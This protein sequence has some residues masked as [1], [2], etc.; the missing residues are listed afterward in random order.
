MT[1]IF[2]FSVKGVSSWVVGSI[3]N[4]ISLLLFTT[5]GNSDN[6]LFC[7]L[8]NTIAIYGFLFFWK[9]VREFVRK[10]K[11]SQYYW[12]L[13][14][15]VL[16]AMHYSFKVR[17]GFE[18]RSILMALILGSL[19]LLSGIDLY[20]KCPSLSEKIAGG[21]FFS[22][23]IF[24]AIKL[25]LV[26]N[27]MKINTNLSSEFIAIYTYTF[28]F[29]TIFLYTFGF[30]LMIGEKLQINLHEQSVSDPLTSI[31]NM[32]GF[33]IFSKQ[34]F[35]NSKLYGHK[36][37]LLILDIDNFKHINDSFGYS[38]GDAVICRFTEVISKNIRERDMFFRI[39]GEEFVI[40]LIDIDLKTAEIIAERLR[41]VIETT[42][43]LNGYR[44]VNFTISIGMA[45]LNNS[46]VQISQ[47]LERAG[48]ALYKAKKSGKNNVKL[49]LS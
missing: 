34:H 36:L 31:Y 40:L 4:S 42:G 11:F 12:L 25:I 7:Y 20:R 8:S 49:A 9:G 17:I 43:V 13:P 1:F 19:T 44:N 39:G 23:S 35:I 47:L 30:L 33:E 15:I 2:K 38:F 37:F 29:V 14:Q 16:V 45:Q 10:D 3:L 26:F 5:Q 24:S 6:I 18:L 22:Y 32:R 27:Y 46:D 48:T 28:S 21:V 41:K